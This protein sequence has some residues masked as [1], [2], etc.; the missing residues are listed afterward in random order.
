MALSREDNRT[1]GGVVTGQS[2]ETPPKALSQREQSALLCERL[3][4][5]LLDVDEAA[6][7]AYAN[8]TAAP[9]QKAVALISDAASLLQSISEGWCETSQP[10]I[11]VDLIEAVAELQST[12]HTVLASS[13]SLILRS[14]SSQGVAA[15][16]CPL[17]RS[18]LRPNQVTDNLTPH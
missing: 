5:L 3:D 8:A 13:L 15:E 10:R 7:V 12:E 17:G 6:N 11:A 16:K 2:D 1:Y 4:E 18:R 9:S 14:L